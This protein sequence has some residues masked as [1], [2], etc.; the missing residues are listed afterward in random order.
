MSTQGDAESPAT[1]LPIVDQ[2]DDA[3]AA[4]EA[5]LG[6]PQEYFEINATARLVNL[7]V[8]LN[9]GAVAQPWLY[10]D[11]EL[12]SSAGQPAAGGTLRAVDIDLDVDAIFGQLLI[13]VPRATV[14][15]FYIHGDGLGSVRYGA[16]VTTELGGGLDVELLADGTI[17]SVDPVD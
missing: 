10:L 15:S 3:I 7:F 17:V 4:L 13:E 9:D 11:G 8:A 14:A 5:R 16:L 6:S 2:I 1:D 12:S